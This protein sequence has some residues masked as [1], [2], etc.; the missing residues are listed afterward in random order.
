MALSGVAAGRVRWLRVGAAVVLCATTVAGCRTD[1]QADPTPSPTISVPSSP[2]SSATPTH[3]P[4]L[5][6][7]AQAKLVQQA[8]SQFTKTQQEVLRIMKAGGLGPSEEA[9]SLAPMVTGMELT[10]YTQTLRSMRSQQIKWTSGELVVWDTKEV[11]GA[12]VEGAVVTISACSDGT[13]VKSTIGAAKT[14]SHGIAQRT[15]ASYR[16]EGRLLK[17]FKASN[18]EDVKCVKS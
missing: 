12:K 14:P 2:V 16:Y 1:P 6:E 11:V 18:A 7:D 17:M 3:T 13:R 10:Y 9:E 4:S 8:A 15:T 5:T